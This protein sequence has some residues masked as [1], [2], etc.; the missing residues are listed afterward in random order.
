MV[1]KT[2]KRHNKLL[3]QRGSGISAAI[4]TA[5]QALQGVQQPKTMI[6]Q[7]SNRS[8]SIDQIRSEIL[9]LFNI[10]ILDGKTEDDTKLDNFIKLII[11]TGSVSLKEKEPLMT[12]FFS[13]FQ[14]KPELKKRIGAFY[15][16]VHILYFW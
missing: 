1:V 14:S 12:R 13:K 6:Q 16:K 8:L 2:V 3:K 5:K 9:K 15:T 4:K 11:E 7:S 10:T